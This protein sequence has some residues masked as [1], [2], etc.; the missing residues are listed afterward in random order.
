MDP[1]KRRTDDPTKTRQQYDL[2][3]LAGMLD[4]PVEKVR[5]WLQEE[6]IEPV[7]DDQPD[8]YEADALE[9]LR[10]RDQTM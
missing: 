8:L 4:A 9:V 7:A 2:G 1:T 6:G 10:G 5:L 3:E